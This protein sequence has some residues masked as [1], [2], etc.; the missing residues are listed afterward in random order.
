MCFGARERNFSRFSKKKR[1]LPS[2]VRL[3]PAIILV[4]LLIVHGLLLLA[5]W[6]A[7]ETGSPVTARFRLLSPREADSRPAK[8][9]IL[10][11]DDV[12]KSAAYDS[13]AAVTFLNSTNEESDEL[14]Q[15]S[16]EAREKSPDLNT[17]NLEAIRSID[18]IRPRPGSFDEEHSKSFTLINS[19]LSSSDPAFPKQNNH[20]AAVDGEIPLSSRDKVHAHRQRSDEQKRRVPDFAVIS[21]LAH[22]HRENRNRNS[23]QASRTRAMA[24]S[25]SA[26]TGGHVRTCPELYTFVWRFGELQVYR[27]ALVEIDHIRL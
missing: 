6:I 18:I 1:L 8:K 12:K 13:L 16:R 2:P 24:S 3:A 23:D 9:W 25:S 15:R 11:T 20:G 7:T 26:F 5:A 19:T 27:R 22:V 4:A 10:W 21:S 14:Y 17:A